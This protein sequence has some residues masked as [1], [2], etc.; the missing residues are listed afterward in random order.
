MENSEPAPWMKEASAIAE[1]LKQK[2]DAHN[3][4]EAEIFKQGGMPS[5]PPNVYSIKLE[6]LGVSN[7]RY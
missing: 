5:P 2:R 4:Q 6:E 7:I 1:V 3:I